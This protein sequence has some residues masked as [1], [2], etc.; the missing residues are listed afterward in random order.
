MCVE[1]DAMAAAA[2]CRSMWQHCCCWTM[3]L[4]LGI[5]AV[6]GHSCHCWSC[7]CCTPLPLLELPLLELPLLE[8]PLLELPLLELPLLELPLLELSL[9]GLSD[10]MFLKTEF[11]FF[12]DGFFFPPSAFFYLNWRIAQNGTPLSIV[13]NRDNLY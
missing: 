11:Q 13:L 3:L 5:G 7:G 8:L 12:D 9:R 4:L 6:A 1:V 10:F 2:Y